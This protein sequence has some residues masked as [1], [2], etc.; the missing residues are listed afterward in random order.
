MIE[1]AI[2]PLMGPPHI[3]T[4][5]LSES[6]S[7]SSNAKTTE[8]AMVLI[9][10]PIGII[11]GTIPQKQRVTRLGFEP[12]MSGPKP[13]VLPLHHRAITLSFYFSKI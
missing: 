3:I 8:L 5:G 11:W 1:D 12:R 2:N 7:A 6:E 13:D 10:E 4:A 9:Q